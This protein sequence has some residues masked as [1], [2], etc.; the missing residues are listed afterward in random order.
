MTSNIQN[1]LAVRRNKCKFLIAR[2]INA[3][4][5]AFSPIFGQHLLF[6]VPEPYL[7]SG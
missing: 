7:S 3:L 5:Y 4:F 2:K 1:N 6:I